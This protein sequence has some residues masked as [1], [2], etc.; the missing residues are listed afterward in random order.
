MGDVDGALTIFEALT[1]SAENVLDREIK[2]DNGDV[3]GKDAYWIDRGSLWCLNCSDPYNP[4]SG[5]ESVSATVVQLGHVTSV[6]VTIGVP[7]NPVDPRAR[8]AW[9]RAVT[10]HHPDGAITVAARDRHELD[11]VET[12]ISELLETMA[13]PPLFN[14]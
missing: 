7:P 6:A 10:L 12:F 9:G 8:L 4:K 14:L 1:R 13:G 2:D 5:P 3:V 11:K